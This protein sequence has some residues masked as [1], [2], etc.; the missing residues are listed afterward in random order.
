MSRIALPAPRWRPA[1]P[2]VHPAV[3]QS[4]TPFHA[5]S[6]P[7]DGGRREAAM[8]SWR[9]RLTRPQHRLTRRLRK[10][11]PRP[12]SPQRRP[13]KCPSTDPGRWP[14][15][16]RPLALYHW[17]EFLLDTTTEQP[18]TEAVA[19]TPVVAEQDETCVYVFGANVGAR[20]TPPR[21]AREARTADLRTWCS[22]CYRPSS[23]SSTTCGDEPLALIL[24]TL[25]FSCARPMRARAA[26]PPHGTHEQVRG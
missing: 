25:C 21:K 14:V 4:I 15:N 23:P 5:R 9:G 7:L 12:W 18:R 3:K 26:S 17:R 19:L 6:L 11:S 16:R 20:P 13:R 2:I 24:I 1:L 22:S 10:R 8:A